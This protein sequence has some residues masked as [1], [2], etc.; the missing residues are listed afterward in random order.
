MAI[1]LTLSDVPDVIPYIQYIATNGQTVYPYPFPITQDSDLVV[2]INGV[3]QGVDSTYS[4]TGQGQITGGNVVLNSGSTVG[5][6]VTIFRDI[7][8]ERLTQFSQNGGFSSSAFNAEFNNV[9]LILQQLQDSISFSLQVPN[10]NNPAPITLLTP[11]T[12]AN[13][14]LAFDSHGNPMPATV[15]STGVLT[16]SQFNSFLGN[17]SAAAVDA[18]SYKAGTLTVSGVATYTDATTITLHAIYDYLAQATVNYR[19]GDPIY[20]H[21]TF[22]DFSSIIGAVNQDHFHSFQ[23]STQWSCTGTIGRLSGFYSLPNVIGAGTVTECSGVHVDNPSAIGGAA[24]TI[25]TLY[26]V[27]V[28]ALTA[29]AANFAFYSNGTTPSVFGGPVSI[30]PYP[31]SATI[32]YEST[33]GNLQLIPR[34]DIA[35][36]FVHVMSKLLIGGGVVV[37]SEANAA[38]ID[39]NSV[40]GTLIITPRSGHG[41]QIAG[42]L[43]EIS[44]SLKVDSSL[45]LFGTTPPA[46]ATGYGTPTGGSHQASFAAGSITLANLAAAV[47]QLVVDLKA[48]GILAA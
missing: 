12:Y 28:N 21:G 18:A 43:V 19:G 41:T 7:P 32:Q 45:G 13:M 4:L 27:Y 29:G 31:D 38:S 9:Y 11:A 35:G 34:D 37:G 24:A 14:F 5:D 6:I 47:A 25:T 10:T 30:G 16:Q 26:G 44:N 48:Y 15:T 42:G 33:S 36:F 1:P 22:A 46:Q 23:S 8:I 20:G 39:N 2:E 40:S 3:T 17:A